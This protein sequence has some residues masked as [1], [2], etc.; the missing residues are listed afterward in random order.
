M[1]QLRKSAGSCG[2]TLRQ[3][4]RT[5]RLFIIGDW[6]CSPEQPK[7]GPGASVRSA[8]EVA[9]RVSWGL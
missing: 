2:F 9:P 3:K 4:I 6:G 8:G 7:R 5:Q 1:V